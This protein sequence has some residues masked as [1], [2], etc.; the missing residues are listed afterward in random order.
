MY[1]HMCIASLSCGSFLVF[2][3]GRWLYLCQDP[4]ICSLSSTVVVRLAH[5]RASTLLFQA[6][7][8]EPILNLRFL[9][10]TPETVYSETSIYSSVIIKNKYIVVLNQ[11]YVSNTISLKF[12]KLNLLILCM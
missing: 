6:E 3:H 7:W 2:A 4:S 5:L 10:Q 11:L 9:Q 8:L 12:F 1:V